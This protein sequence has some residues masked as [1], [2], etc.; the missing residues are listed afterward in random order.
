MLA[1]SQRATEFELDQR[2]PARPD[3]F[4]GARRTFRAVHD[5]LAEFLAWPLAVEVFMVTRLEQILEPFTLRGKVAVVTGA[6][7]GI[8]KATATL[9]AETGA[10]VVMADRNVPAADRVAEDIR[11]AGGDVTVVRCDISSESEILAAFKTIADTLGPVDALVNNAAHR[12]KGEF[13]DISMDLWDECFATIARGAFLCMRCA[14]LQMRASGRGGSV[15]NISTVGSQH[16]AMLANAHYDAAKAAVD[17][18]TRSAAV[19]FGGDGIRVNSLMPG[20]VETEGWGK[21]SST[22]ERRGPAFGP[23]RIL[24]GRRAQPV[25]IARAI[26]FLSSPAASYVTGQVFGVDGGFLAG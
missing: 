12:A 26:L 18:L 6:G 25:E 19:E 3:I 4:D 1:Y 2:F 7:S 13:T 8:G 21:I 10:R 23:G 24:L 22:V 17:S 14:T 5:D 9:F 16:T 11:A 20:P 15:V